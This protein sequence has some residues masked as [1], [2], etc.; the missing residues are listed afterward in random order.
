MYSQ[1]QKVVGGRR[2]TLRYPPRVSSLQAELRGLPTDA[3]QPGVE[4]VQICSDICRCFIRDVAGMEQF[5]A[6]RAGLR[7]A[8]S[9][10]VVGADIV[11]PGIK[12]RGGVLYIIMSQAIGQPW[13]PSGR[14]P[15]RAKPHTGICKVHR[16]RWVTLQSASLKK[17]P[18]VM[19][20]G[21]KAVTRAGR[22]PIGRVAV[23]LTTGANGCVD[24]RP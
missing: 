5:Y 16:R 19:Q 17:R 8:K 15:M 2:T 1:L 22:E 11:E 4:A 24:S 10:P 3:S 7:S 14:N 9:L 20:L 21:A 18:V 6:G 12:Q 13:A 23:G